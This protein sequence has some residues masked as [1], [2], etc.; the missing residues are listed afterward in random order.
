MVLDPDPDLKHWINSFIMGPT[1]HSSRQTDDGTWFFSKMVS[2]G[3]I[4]VPVLFAL[5]EWLIIQGYLLPKQGSVK[6]ICVEWNIRVSSA[7]QLWNTGKL[8]KIEINSLQPK[9]TNRSLE[10]APFF[11]EEHFPIYFYLTFATL[12]DGMRVGQTNFLN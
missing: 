7:P 11:P 4:F 6:T 5:V 2:L 12:I 10:R 8:N 3:A 9:Y 1:L